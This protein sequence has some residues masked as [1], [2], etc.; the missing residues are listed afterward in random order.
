MLGVPGSPGAVGSAL[1]VLGLALAAVGFWLARRRGLV[2]SDL[3]GRSSAA[4]LAL[5]LGVGPFVTWR[6]VEDLRV[7]TALDSYE[8]RESGPIQAFLQ[9]Y[10]LDG[11]HELIPAGAT[12]STAVSDAVPYEA[13]CAA[14]PALALRELFPRRT[15]SDPARA[16]WIVAWGIDPRR[17]A[18][19]ERVL[20]ATKPSGVYPAVYVARVRS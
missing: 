6:I 3:A 5:T 1:L 17:L 10:L 20:V 9:P 11:V 15:V 4:M 14:F 18:P 12:Y 7:T 8:R 13:A 19:V 2:P 16:E